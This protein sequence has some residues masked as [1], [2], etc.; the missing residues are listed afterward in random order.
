MALTNNAAILFLSFYLVEVTEYERVWLQVSSLSR[1]ETSM[2]TIH[3][4]LDNTTDIGQI[5]RAI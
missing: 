4:Y 3:T 5:S 2:P 1:F